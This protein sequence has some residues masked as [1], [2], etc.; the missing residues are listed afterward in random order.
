MPL[1]TNEGERPTRPSPQPTRGGRPNKTG[2][3]PPH[4]QLLHTSLRGSRT[5]NDTIPEAPREA[6]RG[7]LRLVDVIG[8]PAPTTTGVL[9]P[10]PARTNTVAVRIM[11]DART[12]GTLICAADEPTGKHTVPQP[13]TAVAPRVIR[14]AIPLTSP[15][16]IRE[17]AS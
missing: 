11:R 13:K 9:A 10:L 2:E 14:P 8:G 7:A 16:G 12:P 6:D 1:G 4:S 17:V 15:R 3:L 5:S